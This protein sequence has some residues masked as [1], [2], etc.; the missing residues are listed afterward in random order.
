MQL[1]WLPRALFTRGA[2][3]H[4]LSTLCRR[5]G[6]AGARAPGAPG[7]PA[8]T[9]TGLDAVQRYLSSPPPGRRAYQAGS[10]LGGRGGGAAGGGAAGDG[11]AGGGAGAWSARGRG[12][13]LGGS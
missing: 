8:A 2:V 7:R 3:W 4:A 5:T 9:V 1:V 12:Q 13:K 6:A 10:G 11:A